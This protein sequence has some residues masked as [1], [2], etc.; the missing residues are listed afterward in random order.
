M[1]PEVLADLERL[2][3]S[4]RSRSPATR[5][6]PVN[7]MAIGDPAVCSG[8]AGVDDAA[9]QEVPSGYPARLRRDRQVPHGIA[10]RRCST[11]TTT[12]SRPAWSRGGPPIRGR[13]TA[14]G[15]RADLRPRGRRRQ[16]RLIAIHLGTIGALRAGE[17]PCTVQDSIVE[18]ME[19][20][21]SEHRGVRRG[22]PRAVRLPTS[23]SSATWGTSEVGEPDAHERRSAATSSCIVTVAH[24]RAPAALRG[25]RR[26]R[27]RRD[28]GARPAPGDPARRRRATWPSRAS[29]GPTWHGGGRRGAEDFRAECRHAGRASAMTGTGS[30]RIAP[31]VADRRVT[32]DRRST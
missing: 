20:T 25:V 17:P 16:E 8:S 21:D 29:R 27:P 7:E 1:M 19:E 2:V 24:A 13:A 4:P 15:R 5:P 18:G 3:Q 11:R 32:R 23:S 9:L 10:G 26:A 12:C 30:D 31:V 22:T 14:Q 28:D 6:D